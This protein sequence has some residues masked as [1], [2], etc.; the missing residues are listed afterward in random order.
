MALFLTLKG[1]DRAWLGA[2]PAAAELISDTGACRVREG[3]AS[4]Q[5]APKALSVVAT[6]D[7]KR[8]AMI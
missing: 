8:P 2:I 4:D 3:T 6:I 7:L 1:R 5:D